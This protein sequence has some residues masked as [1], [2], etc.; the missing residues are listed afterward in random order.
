MVLV[1]YFQSV[2]ACCEIAEVDGLVGNGLEYANQMAVNGIDADGLVV[3]DVVDGEGLPHWIGVE[4]RSVWVDL[5]NIPGICKFDFSDVV[6][7]DSFG[8][9]LSGDEQKLLPFKRKEI[10]FCNIIDFFLAVIQ[11]HD[12]V[13]FDRLGVDGGQSSES[14]KK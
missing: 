1:F 4:E 8:E 12:G 2:H 5:L 6:N 14:E 7:G 9:S 3:F 11:G 13:H 10:F